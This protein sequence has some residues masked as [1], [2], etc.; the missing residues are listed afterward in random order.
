MRMSNLHSSCEALVLRGESKPPKD[1]G[2][3]EAQLLSAWMEG[4]MVPEFLLGF[5][6]YSVKSRRFP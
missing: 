4:V 2:Y 1:F 3:P 5:W 6:S